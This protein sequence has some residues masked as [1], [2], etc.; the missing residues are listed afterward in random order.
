M[1]TRAQALYPGKTLNA[2][3]RDRF[4]VD[5]TA[6]HLDL[7]PGEKQAIVAWLRSDRNLLETPPIIAWQA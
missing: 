4:G 1:H 3:Q 6:D 7:T 5:R 2:W